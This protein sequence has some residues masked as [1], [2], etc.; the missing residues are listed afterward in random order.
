MA[1]NAGEGEF[2]D[3]NSSAASS[4]WADDSIAYSDVNSGTGYLESSSSPSYRNL[5]AETSANWSGKSQASTGPARPNEPTTVLAPVP[6]DPHPTVGSSQLIFP[7]APLTTR[8]CQSQNSVQARAAAP[9]KEADV[10][11]QHSLYFD[12]IFSGNTSESRQELHSKDAK[13]LWFGVRNPEGKGKDKSGE[14]GGL[15]LEEQGRFNQIVDEHCQ[16]HDISTSEC[17]PRVVSF[18]GDTGAGKS[19]LIRL[20]IE[21]AWKF[22][23][24]EATSLFNVPVIGA[25]SATEPTSVHIGNARQ[26]RSV[27]ENVLKWAH[28]SHSAAVNRFILPHI[29]VVVNQC[30]VRWGKEW[31]P[32]KTTEN[33][34][35]GYNT[36]EQDEDSYFT[37]A[38]QRFREF[39]IEIDCLEDL[40]QQS[41]SSI[42]FIRIPNSTKGLPLAGQL[43]VLHGMIENCTR[44]SQDQKATKGMKLD[45]SSL[46][47]F[48]RLAFNHYSTDLITPF[49]FLEAL[50]ATQPLPD[51][52]S[53]RILYSMKQTFATLDRSQD[54]RTPSAVASE[55]ATML[56]PYICSSIALDADRSYSIRAKSLVSIYKGTLNKTSQTC[57]NSYESHVEKA[58]EIFK[59]RSVECSF[60]HKNGVQ[61]VNSSIAHSQISRHQDKDGNIIGLGKFESDICDEITTLWQSKMEPSLEELDKHLKADARVSLWAIHENNLKI[62]FGRF[63]ELP[64]D[65]LSVCFWCIRND[66]TE[67]LPCGHGICD[68]CITAKGT[69]HATD[70]RVFDVPSCALHP[71]RSSFQPSASF[72]ILPKDVG[73]RILTI[74]GG[75]VRG[76]VSLKILADIER[77]LG[78]DISVAALFDLIGGT[79]SGGLAALALGLRGWKVKDVLEKA[80]HWIYNQNVFSLKFFLVRAFSQDRYEEKG[81]KGIIHEIFGAMSESRLLGSMCSRV[82][83]TVGRKD[84]SAK[85]IIST[86]P[87]G[88][89]KGQSAVWEETDNFKV[90]E[91]A[92]LTTASPGYFPS[93]EHKNEQNGCSF[94]NNGSMSGKELTAR[95]IFEAGRIWPITKD[96]KLDILLSIGSGLS[97]SG[98]ISWSPDGY[99]VRNVNSEAER[100]YSKQA[101]YF[102]LD[103]VVDGSL[104]SLDD[105]EAISSDGRLEKVAAEYLEDEMTKTSLDDAIM[106]LLATSFYFHQTEQVNENDAVTLKGSIKCRYEN[107]SDT[108]KNIAKAVQRLQKPRIEWS[109]QQP[110]W[111]YLDEALSRMQEEGILELP[112]IALKFNALDEPRWPVQ[113]Q[114]AA[115]GVKPKSISGFPKTIDDL[116]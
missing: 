83:V 42:R 94:Y 71:E 56:I 107:G 104:P 95:A 112:N 102:R 13:S 63:T 32:E 36:L 82:F 2:A 111:I 78:G 22:Q 25:P 105:F 38:A 77:R 74:D 91:A 110:H 57:T 93:L 9:A 34:L 109:D 10:E 76:L 17:Y 16:M 80:F 26:M 68:A 81:L 86:Y 58:L 4:G 28:T 64:P 66:A 19:S 3:A 24:A 73:R 44:E 21:Q 53:G 99:L 6:A 35:K 69:P 98:W 5:Q 39:G 65:Q 40:L 116:V 37:T 79:G 51:S 29:I 54:G 47:H 97:R 115:H 70:S 20:L 46:D 59:E 41:Y 43:R 96:K 75:A 49:N 100:A 7:P 88:R 48:F 106:T 33:I 1:F 92:R 67:S 12:N 101:R 87:R 23:D 27:L 30:D 55:F 114:L 89:Y 90:W 72:L 14:S 62:L 45:S 85:S 52:L 60:R 84:L 11:E 18:I 61:C 113:V 103:P 31:N 50:F 8:L 15:I 108:T